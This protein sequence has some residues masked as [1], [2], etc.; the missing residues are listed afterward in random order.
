MRW[1]DDCWNA[2]SL[3]KL[4]ANRKSYMG[5]SHSLNYLHIRMQQEDESGDRKK[6]NVLYARNEIQL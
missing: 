3:I 2:P 4:E 6:I 5:I 1:R